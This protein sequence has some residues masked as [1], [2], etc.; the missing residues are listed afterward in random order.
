VPASRPTTGIDCIFD[1]RNHV[2]VDPVSAKLRVDAPIRCL[3]AAMGC[4]QASIF[5]VFL[6]PWYRCIPV[7]K[8]A[9]SLNRCLNLA[10]SATRQSLRIIAPTTPSHTLPHH[11]ISARW[12]RALTQ[13]VITSQTPSLLQISCPPLASRAV[14]APRALFRRSE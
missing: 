3:D 9:V 13:I 4:L 5:D 11:S 6:H 8:A 14:V 10:C 7:R 2:C 12:L 1:Q